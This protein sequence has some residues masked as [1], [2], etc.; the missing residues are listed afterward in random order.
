MVD[1]DRAEAHIQALERN[2]PIE[3]HGNRIR[4]GYLKDPS[5]LNGVSMHLEIQAPR[6]SQIQAQSSSGGI[7]VDGIR[8]P[9]QTET[10]SGLIDVRDVAA[11]HVRAVTHSGAITIQKVDGSVF[12]QNDSGGI[13]VDGSSDKVTSETGSGRIEMNDIAGEIRATTHSGSIVIHKA[14]GPV[15]VRNDSGSIEA[16]EVAGAI[17]A[18]TGSGAIRLS[19]AKPAP[20]RAHA[21]SGAIRVKLVSGSG[22]AIV[23][24]S[25]HG[26]VSVPKKR[27][28]GDLK[29]HHVDGKIGA[30]GPLV[31]LGTDSSSISI[32]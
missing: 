22:Y 16:T 26:K 24:R 12:A 19:Q 31:D 32:D 29:Q 5:L 10:H 21:D 27:V 6:E 2:P 4:I 15:F 7:R 17:D 14:N 18:Q 9:V 23:A 1:L 3:Q 28:E 13:R 20:I 11:G 25:D 8:G 30:G